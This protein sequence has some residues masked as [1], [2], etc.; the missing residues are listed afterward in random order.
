MTKVVTGS[1]RVRINPNSNKGVYCWI[2]IIKCMSGAT[3]TLCPLEI[4]MLF[5]RLLIFF[6]TQLFW[7][8]FMNTIRVSNSLDPDQVWQSQGSNKLWKSWK[9]WKITKK[10]SMHGKI[11]EFEKNRI[12]MEKSWNFVKYYGKTTTCQKTSCR[13]TASF[14][15]TGGIQ[16]LII[17]KCMHG[18]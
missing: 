3:L 10:S 12:I 8:N 13:P 11:M 9:T 4:F 15:A 14:L 1:R 18:L 17:S 5:C 6:Q 2:V 7:K 16:V